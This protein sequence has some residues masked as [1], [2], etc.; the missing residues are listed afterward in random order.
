MTSTV[1]CVDKVHYACAQTVQGNCQALLLP[2][3]PVLN[4]RPSSKIPIDWSQ[5]SLCCLA[6]S[7]GQC[8]TM[9]IGV[10]K[11]TQTHCCGG[12]VILGLGK[13]TQIDLGPG[14]ITVPLWPGFALAAPDCSSWPGSGRHRWSAP[15]SSL[16]S[17]C[18]AA[19]RCSAGPGGQW[20]QISNAYKL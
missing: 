15:H 10:G 13:I 6:N 18:S 1:S 7:W 4:S 8:V 2:W 11:T 5:I 17:W 14:Y 9:T 19:S 16:S 20:S 3:F 12:I